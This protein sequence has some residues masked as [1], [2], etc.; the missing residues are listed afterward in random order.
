MKEIPEC[1]KIAD[2][3]AS[4]DFVNKVKITRVNAELSNDSLG[5]NTSA[6]YFKIPLEAEYLET[7]I[8]DVPERFTAIREEAHNEAVK[9]INSVFPDHTMVR[10]G[11]LALGTISSQHRHQDSRVFHRFCKRI[12][13][14]IVTN[15]LAKLCVGDNEYHLLENTVWAFNNIKDLHYS[16]NDGSTTRFH[17]IVDVLPTDRLKFILDHITGN[18]FYAHWWSWSKRRDYELMTALGIQE[19]NLIP[20]LP[21]VLVT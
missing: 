7:F 6:M 5:F 12:H 20:D 3:S 4:I 14:P 1:Y 17:I 13:W 19:E 10:G 21:A 16:K 18:D 8:T 9:M 11:L 2:Y 15:P